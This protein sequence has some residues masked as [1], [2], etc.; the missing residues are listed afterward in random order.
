M[1]LFRDGLLL[2]ESMLESLLWPV[3]A[4][5][6]RASMFSSPR[7]VTVVALMQWLVKCGEIPAL[8]VIFFIISFLTS[9]I[10]AKS[11]FAIFQVLLF[12]RTTCC[13]EYGTV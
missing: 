5:M 7:T 2:Y 6:R 1:E 3:T 12:L 9:I 11:H 4:R 8:D 10:Q 13:S